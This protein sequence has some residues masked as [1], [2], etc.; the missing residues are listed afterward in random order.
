MMNVDFTP[1]IHWG[2]TLS[3]LGVL[4]FL[5]FAVGVWLGRA[6]KRR[7]RPAST[8]P[9]THAPPMT[10][11]QAPVTR[12]PAVLD[13]LASQRAALISGCVRTRG[14]LDDELLTEV[15]DDTLRQGGVQIVNPTGFRANP[16][17]HRTAGTDPAPDPHQDGVISRTLRPGFI[18]AG[19]V[20]RAADVVVYKWGN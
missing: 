10:P 20:V 8:P 3:L 11:P 15:L 17:E 6:T 16:A 13:R 5:V 14:M 18:D 12:D 2:Y 1:G 19:R 9:P 7:P 4:A